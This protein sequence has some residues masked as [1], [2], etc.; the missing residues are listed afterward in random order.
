MTPH[1]RPSPPHLKLTRYR[2]RLTRACCGLLA[3]CDRGPVRVK[4]LVVSSDRTPRID[5][6]RNTPPGQTPRRSAS[7]WRHSGSGP[8]RVRFAHFPVGGTSPDPRG[9]SRTGRTGPAA[10]KR[11]GIAAS[12]ATRPHSWKTTARSSAT[13]PTTPGSPGYTP[14]SWPPCGNAASGPPSPA[15]TAT[16]QPDRGRRPASAWEVP[17]G[18][19]QVLGAVAAPDLVTGQVDAFACRFSPGAGVSRGSVAGCEW[20]VISSAAWRAPASQGACPPGI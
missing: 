10:N 1:L 9:M 7:R 13:S 20:V 19:W 16:P 8:G 3:G 12:T 11:A 6:L 18:G 14:R 2:T 4:L 17:A 5:Q 15:L